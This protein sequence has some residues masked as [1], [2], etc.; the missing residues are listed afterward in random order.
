MSASNNPTPLQ[1]F[2][3]RIPS[4]RAIA[5][6]SANVLS[7]ATPGFLIITT[8]VSV[9]AAELNRRA[10]SQSRL[11]EAVDFFRLFNALGEWGAT[12]SVSRALKPAERLY[13]MLLATGLITSFVA[14]SALF[15]VGSPLR[16]QRLSLLSLPLLAS[17]I[18]LVVQLSLFTQVVYHEGP[19][20]NFPSWPGEGETVKYYPQMYTFRGTFQNGYSYHGSFTNSVKVSWVAVGLLV[21]STIGVATNYR[22]KD[23]GGITLG[24]DDT[25]HLCA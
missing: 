11:V 4:G 10:F 16:R 24:D 12:V 2:L 7:L 14:G 1:S 25:E 13:W 20:Y 5:S 18:M 17:I 21:L 6:S 15:A 19:V 23:T 9:A 3:G 22:R 8:A